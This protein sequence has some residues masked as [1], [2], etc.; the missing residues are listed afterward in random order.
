MASKSHRLASSAA[1]SA[2]KSSALPRGLVVAVAFVTIVGLL[3]HFSLGVRAGGFALGDFYRQGVSAIL[4]VVV[5]LLLMR[6]D[7]RVLKDYAN[8]LYIIAVAGLLLVDVLG[9]TRLGATR[10]IS[11]GFVQLQPSEFAKLLCII[12]FAK[13]TADQ[14]LLGRPWQYLLKSIALL[15]IPTAL[16]LAQP[17]L[18]TASVFVISWLAIVLSSKVPKLPLLA[19][20]LAALLMLPLGYKF[21]A[22]YQKQRVDSFLQNHSDKQGS[23]Y[24]V[25]QA[26]IAIG[27]GGLWGRGLMSG[28]QSEGN[29]LPSQSTDFVFAVV[30]EKLGFV[31][32]SLLIVALYYIVFQ[33]L[34]IGYRATDWFG[35]LLCIGIGAMLFIHV[36]VNVGMNL[37]ILPVT[38]IPLIFVSL[39]G[40]SLIVL[41]ASIGIVLSVALRSQRLPR[42]Q[43]DDR[44]VY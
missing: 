25:K 8:L 24:N 31:G 38:G 26:Q 20:L 23:G 7:Y 9:A 11:L 13:Y 34:L 29:F 41:L 5:L 22:P 27:S 12:F 19:I 40:S 6:L 43:E 2:N 3:I 10:W 28:S 30:S 1:Q 33:V 18:G 21:L 15:A 14:Q 35:T 44:V 16:V 17:D 4:G 32:A 37:G 39:G 36:T 42:Y